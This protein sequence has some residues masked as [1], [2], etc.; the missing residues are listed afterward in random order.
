[1]E[2]TRGEVWWADLPDP[3]ASS[4]GGT[5]PI[6]II[7]ANSFNRSRISTVLAVA[8]TTNER[9]A[10]APGNVH[11]SPRDTGLKLPSVAIVSQIITA[12]RMFL[13]DRIGRI[14]PE[15]MQRVESGLRLILGL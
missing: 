3:V 2:V 12:D 1:V 15:V 13:R 10:D 6:L 14:R 11:L 4:P 8:V 7:Q 5:R 9:L